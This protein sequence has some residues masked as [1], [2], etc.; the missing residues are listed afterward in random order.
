MQAQFD[1]RGFLDAVI[2]QD[3]QRLRSFFEPDAVVVWAN[4]SEQFTV[5]E[6]I[7]ANCE[8]PGNWEGA[9][10][11]ISALEPQG[12]KIVFIANVHN[13]EGFAA[14]AVSFASLSDSQTPLINRLVEYWGDV[15]EPPQWRKEK[16][17]GI[18]YIASDAEI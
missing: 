13:G 18:K 17:I 5:D 12:K 6:Y 9:L 15:D 11:G 8:Y 1:V 2:K 7:R 4:T 16:N 14:R 3:A 10:D